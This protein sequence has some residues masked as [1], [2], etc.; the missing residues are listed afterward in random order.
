MTP[1]TCGTVDRVSD[2]DPSLLRYFDE[3]GVALGTHLRVEQV[4]D[5]AGVM[6]LARTSGSSEVAGLR[7]TS[8]RWR[9][10]P[11][12]ARSPSSPAGRRRVRH[13]AAPAPRPDLS[14]SVPRTTVSARPRPAPR[15][16]HD[17][18]LTSALV[19]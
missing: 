2:D 9:A 8:S 1:G 14:R 10:A 11:P 19:A 3:L 5:Y 4:R 7:G 15:W 13:L 17:V 12:T 18:P 16:S 6:A